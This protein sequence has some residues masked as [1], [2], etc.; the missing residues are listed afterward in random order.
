MRLGMV[1]LGRMGANMTRRLMRGR[2]E[3]VVSDLS[4]DNVKHIAAEGAIASASLDDFVSKLA[5]PRVA[6][7]MVPAGSPTEQ[8]VQALAQKFQAG[9]ILIDGGNSYFKDD[10]RR[11]KQLKEKGIHYVDVGTSGGVWGLDRGY[12]MMIGGPREAVQQLDPIFKTLAPG[13]GDIPRTP[14]REMLSGTAEEG[15]IYCG[16][17]GAGHFVKMVHNGIEYGLMQAYAEGFDIFRNAIS[18]E[19]PEDQRY[20][21]NLPDIAEVWRRG[22]VV[23]SWLLDLTAMALAENP[24]LSEYTGFVQDSGEGRWTIQAAIDEAV[25]V[26]V[27]SAALFTRFRSR[28]EHTFAEKVLSAMRQKFGGHV[29]PAAAAKKSA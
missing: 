11:S 16:P 13:R 6:W 1:G 24:T 17:S 29:E 3:I 18:K 15:Y 26:D 25:P 4:A 12:C 22:S 28:Q 9:D 8:T 21:L 27:L 20:D 7:L 10:I 23:S 5:K 19:L 14:G 2:H